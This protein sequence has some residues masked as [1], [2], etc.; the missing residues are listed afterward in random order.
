MKSPLRYLL[1]ALALLASTQAGAQTAAVIEGVQMPAWVERTEAGLAPRRI[2]ASP[3]MALKA[4]DTLS[5]GPGSRLLLKLSERSLVKLGENGTAGIRG[6]DLWG[7]SSPDK[8]SAALEVYGVAD[9]KIV[10]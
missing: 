6:T 5:T 3:G 7:K 8:Q 9:P 4:G 10:S 1:L 2:P